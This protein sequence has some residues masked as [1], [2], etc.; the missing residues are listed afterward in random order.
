LAGDAEQRSRWRTI[1]TTDA[2]ITGLCD[3][4]DELNGSLTYDRA[5]QLPEEQIRALTERPRPP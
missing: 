1:Q 2:R 5:A 4:D 3:V